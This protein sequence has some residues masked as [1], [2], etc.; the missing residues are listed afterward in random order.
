M[1]TKREALAQL[2]LNL[3]GDLERIRQ[4]FNGDPRISLIVRIEGKPEGSLYLTDDKSEEVIA[5]IRQRETSS[6]HV[7][8]ARETGASR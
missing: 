4:R 1:I 6:E 3:C 8:P 2:H 5:V 7:F